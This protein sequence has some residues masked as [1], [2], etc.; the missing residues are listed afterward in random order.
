L[1]LKILLSPLFEHNEIPIWQIIPIEEKLFLKLGG[2]AVL[3]LW[4]N[5]FSPFGMNRR[6]RILWVKYKPLLLLC[7]LWQIKHMS[8]DYTNVGE[9]AW[10]DGKGWVTEW[11]PFSS[12]K[13]PI[14]F[15][16]YTYDLFWNSLENTLVIAH[17]RDMIK[18]IWMS[19]VCKSTKE[20]PRIKNI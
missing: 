19:Y 15:Q 20:V 8:E 11:K 12:P 10:S 9:M 13:T 6:K 5:T 4:A 14:P 17:E 16:L 2:G 18:G 7:P 3:L 1:I